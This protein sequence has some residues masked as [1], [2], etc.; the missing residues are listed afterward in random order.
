MIHGVGTDLLKLESI[1][2]ASLQREDPFYEKMFTAAEK[3][4]AERKPARADWLRRRFAAKEAVFKALHAGGEHARLDQ[5]EILED[6]LGAPAVTL[7]GALAAHAQQAGITAI[8]LSLSSEGDYA[9]AFAVA[10]RAGAATNDEG[11]EHG[12]L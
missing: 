5:I 6:R 12:K 11:K 9:L 8:H 7:H 3:Q 1:P 4:L 2:D 10:E